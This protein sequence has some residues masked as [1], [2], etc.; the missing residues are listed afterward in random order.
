MFILAIKRLSL[1]F[2][3]DAA[4]NGV[5]YVEARF[6]PHLM[7]KDEVKAEH[8][9][10]TVCAAFKEGESKYGVK[11]RIIL[12]CIIGMPPEVAQ[13]TL[14]LCQRFK[15]D[16]VVGVDI[17]GDEATIV[18][19]MYNEQEKQV[20]SEARRLGIHRTVHA[21][22]DGPSEHV[23]SALGRFYRIIQS[24]HRS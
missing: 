13:E 9:I 2:C 10:P 5:L 15:D 12:C 23:T 21:G 16:G 22:E 7:A 17:A 14:E 1:E 18:G 11:A 3:E 20:F 8:V 4:A 19:D 6:S 24:T